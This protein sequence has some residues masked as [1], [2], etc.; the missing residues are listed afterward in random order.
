M[1]II[2]EAYLNQIV[3]SDALDYLRSLPDASVPMFLFSPPYNLGNTTGGGMRD[4]K[5]GRGKWSGKPM[6]ADGYNGFD[7]NVP[8]PEYIASQKAI[9]AECWRCL[10]PNGAIYYNHKPRIQDGQLIHPLMF[11]PDLTVRQIVIWDRG[12]GF[13]YNHTFYMPMQEW[14]V[15]FAKPRFCLKSQGASGVG[16]VW[17][18]QPEAGTWHPAPFPLALAERAIET[19]MPS[20]IVDPFMGRG[21]TAVAAKKMGVAFAGCDQSAAYVDKARQWVAQ[22]RKLTMRQQTVVEMLAEQEVAL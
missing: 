18:I 10:T 5:A 6:L 3:V 16:D 22:T 21:T 4:A 14:I 19:V 2:P 8:W 7:D 13:N 1:T 20:L 9:L 17:T 12:S 11:N 15:I